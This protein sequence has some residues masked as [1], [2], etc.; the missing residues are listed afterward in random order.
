M[1]R[2]VPIHFLLLVILE[3]MIIKQRSES[4][5]K[6]SRK[7]Q[8]DRSGRKEKPEFSPCRTKKGEKS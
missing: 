8:S 5:G 6:D 3:E 7:E 4:F 1:N 2:H